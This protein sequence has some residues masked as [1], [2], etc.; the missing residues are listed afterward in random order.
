MLENK[1]CRV[2][3]DDGFKPAY[4]GAFRRKPLLNVE[5]APAFEERD[6]YEGTRLTTRN[7]SRVQARRRGDCHTGWQL[8]SGERT[9]ELSVGQFVPS[10]RVDA[11]ARLRELSPPGVLHGLVFGDGKWSHQEVRSGD[12]LHCVALFGERVAKFRDMFDR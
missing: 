9:G 4:V 6:R 10:A 3:T 5:L 7:I 8:V 12:H 11:E 2:L 1:S